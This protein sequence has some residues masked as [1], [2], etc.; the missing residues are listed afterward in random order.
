MEELTDFLMDETDIERVL[1][2]IELSFHMI[3]TKTRD[4]NFLNR[5]DASEI[6]D[7]AIAELNYRFKEHG[8]GFQ[9][10]NGSIIRIDS[11]LIHAEIVKPALALLHNKD[12][13]G[14][15][16]EFLQAHEHYRH[17]NNKEALNECLKAFES[18]MKVI[19]EKRQ[20]VY[21]PRASCRDLIKVCFEKELIPTFWQ[22]QFNSLKSLLEGSVPT[23]RNNLSGHGQGST[24]AD[25]PS[26]LV[27]YMLHMTASAIV[28][29][30]E[31]ERHIT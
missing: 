30:V 7:A 14:A 15:E 6:A 24:L 28:F 27:A 26:Y 16:E 11:E 22:S 13:S 4:F 21:D 10:V 5:R 9:F 17:G 18:T 2:V 23:G 19:C 12:F 8:V 20:W 3:D 31:A 25:V 29:M 1:D